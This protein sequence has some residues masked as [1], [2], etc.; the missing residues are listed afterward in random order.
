MNYKYIL[1]DWFGYNKIFFQY[2]HNFSDNKTFIKPYIFFTKYIGEY[3]L[4]PL[5]FLLLIIFMASYIVIN[6]QRHS[7]SLQANYAKTVFILLFSIA[8]G[9]IFV[10][11]LKIY[12]ALPRPYC[13]NLNVINKIMLSLTTFKSSDCYKSFPSGHSWYVATF[14]FSIWG[15][16]N[17]F[18]KV[19]GILTIATVGLSRIIVGMHF[20][21]DVVYAILFASIICSI[22]Y[23]VSSLKII[24]SLLNKKIS[25]KNN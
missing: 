22:A 21:A 13:E 20:P 19:I 10:E 3:L 18:F 15:I 1:Y 12:F 14:I 24:S 11:A 6:K 5:H 25:H 9:A 23:K 2:I 17:R 16:L 4:F 8:L 7:F